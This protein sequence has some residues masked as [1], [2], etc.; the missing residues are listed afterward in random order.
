[1]KGAGLRNSGFSES[2]SRYSNSPE[3]NSAWRVDR[4]L[5]VSLQKAIAN[6]MRSVGKRTAE[7]F[8]QWKDV[9]PW[10]DSGGM[11]KRAIANED[12]FCADF[13]S[14]V[15]HF[16][17]AMAEENNIQL[18]LVPDRQRRCRTANESSRTGLLI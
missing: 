12:P 5:P 17:A 14:A 1:M 2:Q 3:Q 7:K 6:F 18:V 13:S 11:K 10:A 8:A 4:P 16:R 15:R 9:M